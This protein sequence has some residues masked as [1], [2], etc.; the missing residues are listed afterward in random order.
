[1]KVTLILFLNIFLVVSNCSND[2]KA[3]KDLQQKTENW[4]LTLMRS[5]SKAGKKEQTLP[6][7]E[8]YIFKDS[9]FTKSR[10][11]GNEYKEAWGTYKKTKTEE[12]VYYNLTFDHTSY[13]SES[14]LDEK[15]EHLLLRE[16]G[17]MQNSSMMCDKPYKEYSI[18]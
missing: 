13:I 6:Y 18:E 17:K 16:D 2:K 8:N 7:K 4:E 5:G 12:G 3:T 10:L 15:T 9:T 14:C 11:D 1:M